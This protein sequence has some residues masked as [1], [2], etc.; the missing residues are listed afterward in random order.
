[1]S[2]C[3]VVPDTG[4]QIVDGTIVILA[5]F[6]GTKWIVHNGWYSYQGKQ[7]MG[8]YFC[9]IPAQT[10]IPVNDED[11]RL[12]TVVSSDG[13]ESCPPGPYPPPCPPYPPPCPPYPPPFVPGPPPHCGINFTPQMADELDRAWITV[14]TIAQRDKLNTRLLPNGKIVKVNN[15]SGSV[16]YYSWN[17]ATMVWDEETFG[18]NPDNFVTHEELQGAVDDAVLKTDLSPAIEK[19]INNSVS[20]QKTIRQ[21]VDEEI[22]DKVPDMIEESTQDIINNISKLENDMTI[23]QQEL[24]WKQ[25]NN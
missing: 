19:T 17:Q 9:S 14:E 8:W 6:P 3:L 24:E 4:I 12:L 18:I 16:K 7:Y 11:L 13:G 5:R 25:L 1:M 2:N 10:I 20:V 15:V 21:L 22:D 23:I